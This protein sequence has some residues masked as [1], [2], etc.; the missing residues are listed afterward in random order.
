MLIFLQITT[1]L[2][3]PVVAIYRTTGNFQR[4]K[5]SNIK[6][7][8]YLLSKIFSTQ[9]FSLLNLHAHLGTLHIVANKN[10]HRK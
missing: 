1:K 2:I 9:R 3:I 5:L 10:Q 6:L 4:F 8:G 7:F